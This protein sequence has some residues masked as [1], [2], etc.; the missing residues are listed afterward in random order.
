MKQSHYESLIDSALN[1]PVTIKCDETFLGTLPFHK[2]IRF[3]GEM[4][5]MWGWAAGHTEGLSMN[6]VEYGYTFIFSS[7]E[8]TTATEGLDDWSS[9]TMKSWIEGLIHGLTPL[10]QPNVTT[11][12]QTERALRIAG[13]WDEYQTAIESYRNQ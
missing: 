4:E 5:I 3:Y 6:T 12:W 1:V 7:D 10:S 11:S 2:F 13:L 9:V 8:L